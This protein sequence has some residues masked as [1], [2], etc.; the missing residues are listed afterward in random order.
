MSRYASGTNETE[1]AQS[2][3]HVRLLAVLDFSS[4]IARVHDGVGDIA[5]GGDT[6]SGLGTFGGIEEITEDEKV[7]PTQIKLRLSGVASDTLAPALTETYQGRDIT[8]YWGFLDATGAWVATPETLWSGVMDVMRVR[9]GPQTA[10]IEL[11]CEDP[12]YTQP[13]VRTYTREDHQRDYAGDK[14]FEYVPKIPGFRSQ[15][16]AKGYGSGIIVP[17]TIAWPI[18][19]LPPGF[20]LP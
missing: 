20:R 18:P 9:L 16:G 3:V 1:A 11:V 5:F 6:Y 17:P 10:E 7:T 13:Y 2:A 19:G 14:F 12:D 4:G 15:W 8:L